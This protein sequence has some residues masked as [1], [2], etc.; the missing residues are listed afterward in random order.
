MKMIITS[1]CEEC[2]YGSI[3]EADKT[4]IKVKCSKKDK[5]YYY[6]QCIPCEDKKRIKKEEENEE[7]STIQQN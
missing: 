7:S 5:E 6:G 2:I 1:E 4:H 3:V